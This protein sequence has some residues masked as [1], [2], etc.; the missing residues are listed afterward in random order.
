MIKISHEVPLDLL[1][2]SPTFN[3]YDYC[4][5][6]YYLKYDKYKQYYIN[7]RKKGRF[8]ILDNG[9]FEGDSFTDEQLFQMINE[10]QPDIFV[11]PDVW[12]DSKAT[13]ELALKWKEYIP[14][15]P[16]NTKLMVVLQGKTFKELNEL[17][18][19]CA[20]KH[21]F[22]HFGF[23]HSSIA[24]DHTHPHSNPLISKMMGRISSF[25]RIACKGMYYHFLGCSLP[26]EMYLID[27]KCKAHINSVDTSNP[28]VWGALGEKYSE[29]GF[30]VKPKEKIEEFMERDLSFEYKDIIFN[31][32]KFKEFVNG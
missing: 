16:S 1:D 2:N 26:Q 7:A 20:F 14:Q 30:L 3:D 10:I 25:R 21:Q 27:D 29:E 13:L 9:L 15:L 12:N 11:V 32:N 4:L 5:P 24:Y 6:T 23:N 31:I 28:V 8:I 18:D 17:H 19:V 22:T